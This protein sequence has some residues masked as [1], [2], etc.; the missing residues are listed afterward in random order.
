MYARRDKKTKS[1]HVNEDD[2]AHFWELLLIAGYQYLPAENNYLSTSEDLEA[3]IY[4]KTMSRNRFIAIKKNFHID[5]DY[6]LAPSKVAK[7]LPFL[8]I[9]MMIMKISPSQNFSPNF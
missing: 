3:P 4:S 1:F 5:D 2:L 7:V 8:N 9:S 6:N